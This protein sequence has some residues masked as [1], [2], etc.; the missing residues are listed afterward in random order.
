[1]AMLH[2]RI[3]EKWKIKDATLPASTFLRKEMSHVV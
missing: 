1:V 3:D 2:P